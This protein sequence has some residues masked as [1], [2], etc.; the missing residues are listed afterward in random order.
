MDDHYSL[1][2]LPVAFALDPAKL[3]STWRTVAA[4]VHPDRY[5]TADATQRRVAMQWA[6]RANEAYRVLRDPLLRAKYL[7]ERAGV[8]L[9]VESNTAVDPEF[10][11]QQMQWHE[12]LDDAQGQA[13]ALQKIM[14]D[15]E[16]AQA[17][18]RRQ[19][20]DLIDVRKDYQAAGQAV[21]QWMF[22]DKLH[23]DARVQLARAMQAAD[24]A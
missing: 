17:D 20:G 7:C 1:F 6:A 2:G 18:M 15:L 10:L 13:P 19:A 3:E 21:R 24:E 11:M 8:D 4:Q 22:I 12:D 23:R 16:Q 5:A 14:Q 9:Q